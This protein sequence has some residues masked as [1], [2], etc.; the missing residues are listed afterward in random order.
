MALDDVLDLIDA[1]A[2]RIVLFQKRLEPAQCATIAN[3]YAQQA[4]SHPLVQIPH[5]HTLT[6]FFQGGNESLN[7]LSLEYYQMD[8][9][10]D[11]WIFPQ[12]Y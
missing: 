4:E 10:G 2:A 9:Y 1:T 11:L 5:S 12:S 6:T 8:T 7:N 3:A